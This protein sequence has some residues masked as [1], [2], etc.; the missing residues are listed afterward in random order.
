LYYYT[1]AANLLPGDYRETAHYNELVADESFEHSPETEKI[2]IKCKFKWV[3]C[4]E[5][6][7]PQLTVCRLAGWPFG[8]FQLIEC[9]FQV[10]LF[11]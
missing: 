1:A 10:D 9:D 6:T 7:G 2:S 11:D 3:R 8:G 4:S 5:L